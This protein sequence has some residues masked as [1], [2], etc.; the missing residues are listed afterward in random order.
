MPG[1]KVLHVKGDHVEA[2][3]L[4]GLTLGQESFDDGNIDAR[5]GEFGSEHQARRA[6]AGDDHGM[7]GFQLTHFV[8]PIPLKI[9]AMSTFS[10]DQEYPDE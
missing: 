6:S 7:V 9:G 2:H 4:H 8:P 1:G 5:Q 10:S 3:D